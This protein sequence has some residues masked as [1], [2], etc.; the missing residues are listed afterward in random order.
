MPRFLLTP[1]L[2]D[3]WRFY[4]MLES[5]EKSD[6][7]NTLLKTKVPRTPN[8]EAGIKFEDDILKIS[9]GPS[10]YTKTILGIV[11]TPEY[12][13]CVAE[14]A[15]IVQGGLWQERVMFDANLFGI[16][17][18]IY[19]KI[20]VLKRDW[21]Y[22]IKRSDTY[23]VGK[24]TESVQH[25]IYMKGTGVNKFK[26]LIGDDES[27]Y[28]E[29]YR[30]TDGMEAEMWASLRD[31]VS[32]IMDDADFKRAYM[33]NWKAFGEAKKQVI[34]NDGPGRIFAAG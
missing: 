21:I 7:L 18:L 24:Y 16:D 32:G 2:H 12:R 30:M 28:H 1:S 9:S 26:Y 5:K 33:E 8:M 14:I 13:A 3:S 19:G 17:F 10:D 29:E 20:D 31:L 27:V 25:P 11:G 23:E 15:A 4:K 22:D 34:P 6:F